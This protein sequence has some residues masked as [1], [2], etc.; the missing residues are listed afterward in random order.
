MLRLKLNH[1]SKRGPWGQS[2]FKLFYNTGAWAKILPPVHLDCSVMLWH[3]IDSAFT[4]KMST[5]LKLHP[6]NADDI[7]MIFSLWQPMYPNVS[8]DETVF[9]HVSAVGNNNLVH[10]GVTC[11]FRHVSTWTFFGCF[12]WF[13][14]KLYTFLSNDYLYLSQLTKIP[15]TYCDY[16]P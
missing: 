12:I 9:I 4:S 11:R 2:K 3:Y 5:M 1:V 8:F 15:R 10:C 13:S 7:M 14:S 6:I 16:F